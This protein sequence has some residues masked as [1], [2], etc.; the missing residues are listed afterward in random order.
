MN[1]PTLAHKPAKLFKP[2]LAIKAAAELGESDPDW[3][4]IA[5]HDPTGRGLSFIEIF[6]EDGDPV[7]VW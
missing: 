1:G 5:K 3:A 4:Y 6:D 7:G 2:E